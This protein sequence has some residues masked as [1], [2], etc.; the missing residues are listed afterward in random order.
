[1][2]RLLAALCT[3]FAF[4]TVSFVT[5]V[6]LGAVNDKKIPVDGWTC[7]DCDHE[8]PYWFTLCGNCGRINW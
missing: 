7:P 2:I 6:D 4:A 3:I 1:M 8:N 5:K